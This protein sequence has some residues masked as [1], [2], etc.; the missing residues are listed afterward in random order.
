MYPAANIVHSEYEAEAQQDDDDL[1]AT[2]AC[3]WHITNQI[4]AP[5]THAGTK[6]HK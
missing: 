5:R 1:D 3:K 2:N 6:Y 4:T